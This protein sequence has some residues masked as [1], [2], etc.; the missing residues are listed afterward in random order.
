MSLTKSKFVFQI[1]VNIFKV[2]CSIV[3]VVLDPDFN[4][5]QA[6]KAWFESLAKTCWGVGCPGLFRSGGRGLLQ[7]V[8]EATF[9][10]MQGTKSKFVSNCGINIDICVW[11]LLVILK[12]VI[13]YT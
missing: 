9:K 10:V 6:V 1:I 3:G 13:T 5:L 11:L 4:M 12:N 2:R 7:S 8:V